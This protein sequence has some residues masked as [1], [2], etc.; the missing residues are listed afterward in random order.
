MKDI[1]FKQIMPYGGTSS[2]GDLLA[3][4][5]EGQIWHYDSLT[6]Y[7]DMNG[8]RKGWRKFSHYILYE[9]K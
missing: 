7:E 8:Q 2:N 3:L 1:K 5:E 6:M 4:D 9:N